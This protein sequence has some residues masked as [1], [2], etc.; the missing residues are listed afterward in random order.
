MELTR[1]VV[2]SIAFKPSRR[3]PETVLPLVVSASVLTVNASA[4]VSRAMP[5]SARTSRQMSEQRWRDKRFLNSGD[6]D[7]TSDTSTIDALAENALYE[8]RI[9]TYAPRSR[10]S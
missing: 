8:R 7:C 10:M 9:L 2:P 4:Q 6:S 3:E 1:F 5:F